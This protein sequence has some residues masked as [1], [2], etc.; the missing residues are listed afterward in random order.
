MNRIKSHKQN[1]GYQ[2]IIHCGQGSD[3]KQTLICPIC[4]YTSRVTIHDSL[5]GFN[6]KTHNSSI[7][8]P[9][10]RIELQ[11]LGTKTRIPR[12]KSK[13]FRKFMKK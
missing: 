8:C 13:K 7:L 9:E 4:G 5:G 1:K 11:S 6:P 2:E 12:R 3:L 10:H